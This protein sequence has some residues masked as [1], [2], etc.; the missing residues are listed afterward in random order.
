MRS[1]PPRSTSTADR[2]D[3]MNS[4]VRVGTFAVATLVA[5]GALAQPAAT[6]E[7]PVQPGLAALVVPRVPEL[8]AAGVKQILA[9]TDKGRRDIQVNAQYGT[10]Y[11]AWPKGSTPVPFE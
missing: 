6:P 9:R 7:V 2:G 11:L 8:R 3:S 4:I 5:C 1:A 10:S